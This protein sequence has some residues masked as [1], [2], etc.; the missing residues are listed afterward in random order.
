[1]NHG[2]VL[3]IILVR[4]ET[5]DLWSIRDWVRYL[6]PFFFLL[7]FIKRCNDKVE[8]DTDSDFLKSSNKILC[9]VILK[10]Y[11]VFWV[12]RCVTTLKTVM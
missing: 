8:F 7:C 1:M 9:S 2:K 11:D 5:L 3:S 12:G 6:F 4:G 10:M